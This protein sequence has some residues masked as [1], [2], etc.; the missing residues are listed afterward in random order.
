ML[1]FLAV[2]SQQ[3]QSPLSEAQNAID[4]PPSASA[5]TPLY[6]CAAGSMV[7][8]DMS[9]GDSKTLTLTADT[10]T[11]EPF[12][13][14][15]TWVVTAPWD[16]IACAGMVNFSVPGKPDPPPVELKLSY[17][18][19]TG[20]GGYKNLPV[21]IFTDPSGTLGPATKPQ[22]AWVADAS[23]NFRVQSHSRSHSGSRNA[24]D[25][26]SVGGKS[27]RKSWKGP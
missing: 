15:E 1:S 8:A 4:E 5:Q 19:A 13:N 12:G 24:P 17:T 25:L 26:D 7:Y 11:I 6:S 23:V 9:D 18:E 22:N 21:L 20:G 10:L 14:N 16:P 27:R 3:G 2:I